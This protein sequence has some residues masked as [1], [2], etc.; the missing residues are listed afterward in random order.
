MPTF[1]ERIDAAANGTH[2][3]MTNDTPMKMLRPKCPPPVEKPRDVVQKPVGS[4]VRKNLDTRMRNVLL[5][6]SSPCGI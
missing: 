6:C 2:V 1:T 3:S 5:E 4:K